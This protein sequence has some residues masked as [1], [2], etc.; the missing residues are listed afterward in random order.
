MDKYILSY[1]NRSPIILAKVL[2]P[3]ISGKSVC[4][5][6]CGHGDLLLAFM[7]VGAKYVVGIERDLVKG[8]IAIS[9]K[10]NVIIG[11][12]MEVRIPEVDIYYNWL[13]LPTALDVIQKIK[14]GLIIY[15]DYRDFPNID[16]K[17]G[18]YK[19]QIPSMEGDYSLFQIHI[20]KK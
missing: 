5:L 19:I 11:D 17:I 15:G 18:G 9:R 12:V 7:E 4:D 16:N 2:E 1:P 8:D 20:T 3:L 10:L 13:N 6:G 14:S